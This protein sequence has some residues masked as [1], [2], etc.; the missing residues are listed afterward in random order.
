MDSIFEF[1]KQLSSYDFWL[2]IFNSFKAIGPV[3][4]ALFAMVESFIPALPLIAITA[5][6]VSAYGWLVGFLS[7]YIGSC[8][9][10]TITFF[11]FRYIFKRL[12]DKV[13]I[14]RKKVEKARTWIADFDYAALF[15]LLC[16]PF[17]PSS[18]M[19]FAFGISEF[20]K[21]KYLITLYIAKLFMI[22]SL[23]YFGDSIKDAFRYPVKTIIGLLVMVV[24]YIISVKV[25]NKHHLK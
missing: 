20:S 23:A 8:L 17:T 3:P 2:S 9:G 19:N 16:L 14:G 7:T 10:C 1:L 25:R 5:L 12:T 21:R 22:A 24:L 15:L 4:G 6:N 11:F 13:G 18:F